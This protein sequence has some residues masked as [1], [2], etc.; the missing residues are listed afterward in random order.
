V[1]TLTHQLDTEE[2]DTQPPA[3][4]MWADTTAMEN[5]RGDGLQEVFSGNVIQSDSTNDKT[6][7]IST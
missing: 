6:Y 2:G 7:L 3:L 5:L 1:T 4:T